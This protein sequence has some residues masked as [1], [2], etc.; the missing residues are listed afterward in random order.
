M[1]NC[2]IKFI[3]YLFTTTTPGGLFVL[4]TIKSKQNLK[5]FMK[6]EELTVSA[7]FRQLKKLFIY[8]RLST[9][10]GKATST[11][12][13]AY[14]NI[15]I[16]N[17]LTCSIFFLSHLKTTLTIFGHP[18]YTNVKESNT[19][20]SAA[21]IFYNYWWTEREVSELLPLHFNF[22]IDSRNLM[23][24]YFVVYKPYLKAFSSIGI[25]ELFYDTINSVLIHTEPNVQY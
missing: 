10:L 5:N 24:E 6:R 14:D 19:P 9:L 12:Q 25:Y 13:Y 20:D 8:S 16:R 3:V 18:E 1:L 11:E 2:T 7:P 23:M 15:F 21:D 22:K 4:N 17:T